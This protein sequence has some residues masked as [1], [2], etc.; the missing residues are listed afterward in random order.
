MKFPSDNPVFTVELP[1]GW[2]SARD[3]DGNLNCDPRDDSGYAFSILLLKEVHSDKE[4]NAELPQLARSMASGASLKN[5]KM[6]DIE[7]TENGNGLQ[8]AEVKGHGAADGLT[9]VVVVTGFEPQKGRFCAMVSAGS[10]EA[11]KKHAGDY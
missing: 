1:P 3:K 10:A 2:S 4:L 11:D 8:F 7:G 6:G 9:F 5:F